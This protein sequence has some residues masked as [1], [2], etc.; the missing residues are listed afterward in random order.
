MM[1]KNDAKASSTNAASTVKPPNCSY[2]QA[3]GHNERQCPVNKVK[4]AKKRSE[5]K[6]SVGKKHEQTISDLRAAWTI[7]PV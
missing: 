6:G 5:L 2:C 1:A 7:P 4:L 3:M